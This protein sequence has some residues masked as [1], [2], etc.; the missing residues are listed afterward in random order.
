MWVGLGTDLV[1][2]EVD[3]A[4]SVL[5]S[6]GLRV[7]LRCPGLPGHECGAR[8]AKLYWPL[9]P[10][11][12]FACRRCHRLVYRSSQTRRDHVWFQRL[13]AEAVRPAGSP[14]PLAPTKA[15]RNDKRVYHTNTG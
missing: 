6:G 13:E 14:G 12:G 10:P 11:G 3:L 7:Y 15:C 4:R 2:T 8:V 5:R 1:R 9:E